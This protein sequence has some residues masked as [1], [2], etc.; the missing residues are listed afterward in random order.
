MLTP[1]YLDS[2]ADEIIDLYADLE[3]GIIRD[4]ARSIVKAGEVTSSSG[5]QAVR[6]QHMGLLYD[7]IIRLVS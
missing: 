4:I 1:D 5:W 3:D 6:L 2:V 7:D